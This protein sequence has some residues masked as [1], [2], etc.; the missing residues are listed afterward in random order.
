MNTETKQVVSCRLAHL[1]LTKF[2]SKLNVSIISNFKGWDKT[3]DITTVEIKL[4]SETLDGEITPKDFVK[5]ENYLNKMQIDDKVLYSRLST[6][7]YSIT[8]EYYGSY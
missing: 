5:I 6:F 3:A 2:L 1:N 7:K 4:D 8:I